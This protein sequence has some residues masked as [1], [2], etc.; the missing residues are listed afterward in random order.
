[1]QN[2]EVVKKLSDTVFSRTGYRYSF[3]DPAVKN[4]T[5]LTINRLYGCDNVM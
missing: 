1:M 2:P 3:Q 5:K 4:K